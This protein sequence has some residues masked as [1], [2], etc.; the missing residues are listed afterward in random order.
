M[1]PSPTTPPP[2][3]TLFVTWFTWSYSN[4]G[5]SL[6][7]DPTFLV[8]TRPQPPITTRVAFNAGLGRRQWW[9]SAVSEIPHCAIGPLRPHRTDTHFLHPSVWWLRI[10]IKRKEICIL[11]ISYGYLVSDTRGWN[12]DFSHQ[13]NRHK[14][15][16]FLRIQNLVNSNLWDWTLYLK[17]QKE[18]M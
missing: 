16:N 14:T 8:V 1:Y 13:P 7:S 3:G 17:K 18:N 6:V 11:G 10:L 15:G 5:F 12:A 9:P 4:S 2:W